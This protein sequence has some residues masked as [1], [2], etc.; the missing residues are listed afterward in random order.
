MKTTIYKGQDLSKDFKSYARKSR[1]IM[2]NNFELLGGTV[3]DFHIGF[4]YWSGFGIINGQYYYFS[5]FDVRH[6]SLKKILFRTAKHN[7][8]FTGGMNQYLTTDMPIAYQI[9]NII[10]KR[11]NF[12]TL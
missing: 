11:V 8:D 3:T 9:Q 6:F 1:N 12:V 4:Y 7:K 2:K 5:V 10:S